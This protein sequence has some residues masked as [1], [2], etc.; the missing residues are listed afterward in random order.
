MDKSSHNKLSSLR[1]KYSLVRDWVM[2]HTKI[3]MPIVLIVCVLITVLI[4]VN[5]NQRAELEKEAELA[6]ASAET[7]TSDAT[8]TGIA[9]PELELE[10]NAYPEIVSLVRAYYDSLAAGDVDAVSKVNAYL[11]EIEIIRIQELSKY[12]ENY[13]TVDVYTK[14][15]PVDGSYVAYVYSKVKFTDADQEVP[16]MQTYYIGMNEDG[17]YFINDGAYDDTV[18]NYIKEISLQDDVVDLNNIVVVE[19]NDLLAS[20]DELNEFIAYLQEKINEDVGEILAE[21]EAPTESVT[22]PADTQETAETTD[23]QDANVIRKVKAIDVVNIRTSDSE[24]AD[25]IDKAQIGQEFTLLEEKGNGWSKVEYND[26]DAY[27]KSEYLEVI[28]EETVETDDT[29]EVAEEDTDTETTTDTNTTSDSSKGTVKV[30]ENVRV[31]ASAST[32]GELLGT[33]YMGEELELVMKQADGWTKVKYK[34]NTAYVKS[35]YV[36]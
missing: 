3:V 23:T 6:A 26:A 21:A 5:A 24:T 1:E 20:D 17:S 25:K 30:I 10:E 19:Y 35:D 31:R 16:G 36:E 13:T 18:L 11:D 14:M 15:G 8:I 7:A 9:A 33:A 4:A 28:S 27:I 32:D 29:Q 12:I 2:D 34:G 22:E